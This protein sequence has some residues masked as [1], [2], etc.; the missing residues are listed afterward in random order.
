MIKVLQGM[1]C[2]IDGEEFI[3]TATKAGIVFPQPKTK[4]VASPGY[5]GLRKLQT[6]KMEIEDIK[7][8]LQDYPAEVIAMVG[9]PDSVD[10][11]LQLIGVIG[12]KD[13]RTITITVSGPWNSLE[14]DEWADDSDGALNFGVF[15]E[16][17]K[18]E[19]DNKEV[20]YYD[21]EANEV[22][23]DGKSITK[24]L[25]K[26]LKRSKGLVSS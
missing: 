5:A 14:G 7:I 26:R 10:K 1:N 13:P 22:R 15:P 2:F 8:T 12:P 21:V 6:G 23:L 9:H 19:I 3:G 16:E 25:N 24:D 18:L 20:V 4:E 11:A 17:Y